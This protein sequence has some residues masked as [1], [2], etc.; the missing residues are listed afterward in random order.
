M[1]SQSSEAAVAADGDDFD[2]GVAADVA[3]GDDVVA[4]AVGDV[5]AYWTRKLAG[6][7]SGS[8]NAAF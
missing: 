8:G 4:A 1:S 3:V 6:C 7:W 2:G 5:N